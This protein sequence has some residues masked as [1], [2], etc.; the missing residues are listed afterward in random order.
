MW[1]TYQIL[2]P[3]FSLFLTRVDLTDLFPLTYEVQLINLLD[4]DTAIVALGSQKLKVRFSKLDA[5][6]KGQ[7]FVSGSGDAGLTSLKCARKIIQNKKTFT[8]TIYKQDIYGR[9]LGDLDDLSFKLVKSGCVALY[10]HA[11]FSSQSEKWKFLRAYSESR[12]LKKGLWN[13]GGY[14]QPK[15]WRKQRRRPS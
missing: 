2:L 1:R 14:R 6:E 15:L 5:P 3:L 4:G 8:L 10:P 11:E 7:P 13:M 12:R 9:L